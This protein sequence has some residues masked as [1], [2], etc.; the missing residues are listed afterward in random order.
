MKK[1]VLLLAIICLTACSETSNY[2][3]RAAIEKASLKS[4]DG[5]ISVTI[6]EVQAPTP[7]SPNF[8]P[9]MFVLYDYCTKEGNVCEKNKEATF[10]KHD[11]GWVLNAIRHEPTYRGFIE[12]IRAEEMPRLKAE[13]EQMKT[14]AKQKT[15]KVSCEDVSEQKRPVQMHDQFGFVVFDDYVPT[16]NPDY[17]PSEQDQRDKGLRVSI[18]NCNK[19]FQQERHIGKTGIRGRWEDLGPTPQAVSEYK[20]CINDSRAVFQGSSDE[21]RKH[22]AAIINQEMTN[23]AQWD[24]QEYRNKACQEMLQA[25]AVNFNAPN[26]NNEMK[27]IREVAMREARSQYEACLATDKQ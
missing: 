16:C 23:I 19:T 9:M 17:V 14:E 25:K 11:D 7:D 15:L 27:A 24:N 13:M 20:T 6:K 3:I 8:A 4:G 26:E 5:E 12:Q 2:R 18:E 21:E 1:I 10:T 22:N